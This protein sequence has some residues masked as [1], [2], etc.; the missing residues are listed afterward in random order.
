ERIRGMLSGHRPDGSPLDAPHLAFLPLAF[1][2]H[3]YADGRLL[4][5]GLILPAEVPREERRL[6]L[7]AIG[8]VRELVVGRL[9]RWRVNPERR[10]S[11]PWNL[12]PEAWTA[13]PN[14]ATHWSTVTP[15][16]FDRHPK[17]K[18]PAA[19]HREVSTM[20][21]EG[22]RRIG[23]PEPRETIVT[24]VSA[25]PGVPPA[26]AFP[27]LRRKDGS[28]R[29]HTHAILVFDQPVCGPILIG[30][31]RFRGYGVMRPIRFDD[32]A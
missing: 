16:A 11:P 19:Y 1:V 6:A 22:C 24:H 5:M 13:Y 9:G 2:G 18:N 14:G 25:H 12:R 32:A 17:T 31:G 20:I 15:I 29:R 28:E 4:G 23:L 10:S 30:A 8:S 21:A 26:F 7:R 3:E 27:K